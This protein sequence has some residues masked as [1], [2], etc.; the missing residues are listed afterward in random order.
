M[1]MISE[2]HPKFTPKYFS[3]GC[4]LGGLA[5]ICFPIANAKEDDKVANQ[6]QST[7]ISSG[8][9]GAASSVVDWANEALQGLEMLTGVTETE[10]RIALR[11]S[12]WND[13]AE[14]VRAG[15]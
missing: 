15:S 10:Y 1:A 4:N 14:G 11:S 3:G 8:G 5:Y 6:L 13:I 2:D 7:G 9:D 12:F